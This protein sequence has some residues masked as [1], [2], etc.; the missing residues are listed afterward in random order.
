MMAVVDT[1]TGKVY[2]PPISTDLMLP[3]LG[4]GPWL[5][6][7]DFRLN[8]S[9]LVLKSTTDGASEPVHPQCILWKNNRWQHLRRMSTEIEEH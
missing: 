8:S 4:D 6:L 9:L 2:G 5:P 7:V 1:E 3:P